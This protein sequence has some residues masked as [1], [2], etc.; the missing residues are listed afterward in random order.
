MTTAEA[1]AVALDRTVD[2]VI[3]NAHLRVIAMNE[4]GVDPFTQS[5][6]LHDYS[7]TMTAAMALAK[8]L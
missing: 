8:T 6:T 1:A 5:P 3:R 4:F 7:N 2:V